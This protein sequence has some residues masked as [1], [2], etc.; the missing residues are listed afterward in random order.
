MGDAPEEEQY[1]RS[2]EQCRH[3]VH[4]AGHV[5]GVRAELGE[6]V[7][8]EHKERGAGRVTHLQFVGGGDKFR[9][10][11][12]TGCRLHG[13]AVGHRGHHKGQPAHEVVNQGVVFHCF[14]L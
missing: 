8:R 11:P 6:E 1:A 10:V 12:E 13:E 5:L 14:V 4:A 2:R 9:A 7:A 3:N